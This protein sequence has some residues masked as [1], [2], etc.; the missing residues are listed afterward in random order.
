MPSVIRFSILEF[1]QRNMKNTAGIILLFVLLG[2][3]LY[4]CTGNPNAVVQS[5]SQTAQVASFTLTPTLTPIPT[6][7]SE[8][9][10]I[11]TSTEHMESTPTPEKRSSSKTLT[12]TSSTEIISATNPIPDGLVLGLASETYPIEFCSIHKSPGQIWTSLFPFKTGSQ[13]L[14]NKKV[15]FY[16]PVLSPDKQW[17]AYIQVEEIKPVKTDDPHGYYYLYPNSESIWITRLNGSGSKQISQ[18]ISRTEFIQAEREGCF[19]VGGIDSIKGWSSDSK[20]LAFN[21]SPASHPTNN[22][23]HL[24][25]IETG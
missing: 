16:Q 13:L 8:Y 15:G 23:V 10:E 1:S 19:H 2:F 17:I 18:D 9:Q 12:P 14:R 25:N 3:G 5:R 24:I 6:I 7:Q 11:P 4:A 20:W 21:D 22:Q